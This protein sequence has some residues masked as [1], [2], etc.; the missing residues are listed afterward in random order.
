MRQSDHRAGFTLIELLV[1]IGIISLLAAALIN[2]IGAGREGALEG[3]D[4]IKLH[5]RWGQFML[6]RDK[7]KPLPKEGG[8]EFVYYPWVSGAI[9][10]TPENLEAHF[11]S[12][13]LSP[14]LAE[15]LEQDSRTVLLRYDEITSADTDFAGRSA[16]HYSRRMFTSGHEPLL[17]TDNEHGNT[18]RDG[19]V[20]VLYGGGAV[21]SISRDDIPEARGNPDYVI[22]V[23]PDSPVADLRKLAR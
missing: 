17:A 19:T 16:E 21:R 23:G 8:H 7:R 1:V 6:A 20:L 18:Y 10:R 9:E 4:R 15:L 22:E 5:Q 11:V 13:S 3:I 2:G 14:R 12:D